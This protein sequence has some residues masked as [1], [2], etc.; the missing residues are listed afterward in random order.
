MCGVRCCEGE[1]NALVRLPALQSGRLGAP[2]SGRRNATF[3]ELA[4]E[5]LV[6]DLQYASSLRAV[7][8]HPLEDLEQRSTLGIP[9]RAPCDGL[10]AQL[11]GDA[12][13]PIRR[14]RDGTEP[15]AALA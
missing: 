3:R 2:R 4:E 9:G 14:N 15:N 7:P 11:L 6:A 8:P 12:I 10:E 5:G 13:G 1:G